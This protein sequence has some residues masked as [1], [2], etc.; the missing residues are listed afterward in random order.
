[1]TNIFVDFDLTIA[2]G[3]SGG[4]A[5][6][7]DPMDE[8]NKIFIKQKISEWLQ[9]GHNVIIV[10]RG[11]DSHIDG[12]L[13]TLDIKHTMNSFIKGVLSVYAPNEDTFITENSTSKFAIIKTKYVDDFLT[14]SKT[15]S[16]HSIFI[17]D[18]ELNVILMKQTFPEM[19]CIYAVP[20]NYQENISKIDAILTK[21]GGTGS[22]KM[23]S[24]K[25]N[26]KKT[27]RDIRKSRNITG[28]KPK[29]LTPEQQEEENSRRLLHFI[30]TE[31]E[32]GLALDGYLIKNFNIYNYQKHNKQNSI[33]FYNHS[34]IAIIHIPE[35]MQKDWKD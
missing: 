11:I 23:K 18:T 25:L 20:G 10:T 17:D 35:I 12:Y 1:M 6:D 16:K 13:T 26:K 14:K 15:E 28:G 3:H 30:R 4:Y 34:A 27:N 5:M 9:N 2:E 22:R 19:E 33:E 29:P 32:G 7:H 24:R 8:Q 21:Q 31:I